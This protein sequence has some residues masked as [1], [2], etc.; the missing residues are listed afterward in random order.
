MWRRLCR[1]GGLAEGAAVH[2]LIWG[3]H[4]HRLVS[5]RFRRSVVGG[6]GSGGVL[7]LEAGAVG[8][9]AFPPTGSGGAGIWGGSEAGEG[10]SGRQFWKGS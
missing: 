7:M 4:A 10:E 9:N 6:G 2:G 5:T 3:A 8:G 1:A